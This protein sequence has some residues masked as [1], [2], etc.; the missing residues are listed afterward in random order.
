ML[1]CRKMS[2][3]GSVIHPAMAVRSFDAASL[4]SIEALFTPL[5][6]SPCE[7]VLVEARAQDGA[8]DLKVLIGASCLRITCLLLKLLSLYHSFERA[9]ASVPCRSY[10]LQGRAECVPTCPKFVAN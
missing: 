1:L 4:G 10:F 7:P 9:V 3:P 5:L 2:G 8:H 6:F